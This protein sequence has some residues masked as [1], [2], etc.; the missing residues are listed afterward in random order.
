M[1]DEFPYKVKLHFVWLP[2]RWF[3]WE[4]YAVALMPADVVA[5]VEQHRDHYPQVK[6][7]IRGWEEIRC[8]GETLWTAREGV[9]RR[10]GKSLG[11][12]GG[13]G[14]ALAVAGREAVAQA[15]ARD[16]Y[17]ANCAALGVPDG[18]A[19][20][21]LEAACRELA[22]GIVSFD[23]AADAWRRV[24]DVHAARLPQ[25]PEPLRDIARQ[26]LIA[27]GRRADPESVDRLAR[28]LLLAGP[29]G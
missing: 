29:E 7:S 13:Q 15:A 21:A 27:G 11:R 3:E 2:M 25:P 4:D 28:A 19:R 8:C 17:F 22:A 23:P 24:L 10:L 9:M 14:L 20:A 6:Q 16:R 5:A 12:I 18:E 26:A 1:S